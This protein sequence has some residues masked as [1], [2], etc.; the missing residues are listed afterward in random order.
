MKVYPCPLCGRRVSRDGKPFASPAHTQGHIDGSRDD[1]HRGEAGSEHMNVIEQNETEAT[2]EELS[3]EAAE[4]R[5]VSVTIDGESMEAYEAVE[6]LNARV[7]ELAEAVRFLGAL[8]ER[9]IELE[10]FDG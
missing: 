8:H 4:T 3:R 5:D 9:D 7:D 6:V 1:A 2:A 10:E